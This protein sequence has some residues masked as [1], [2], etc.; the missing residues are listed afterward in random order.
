MILLKV[1]VCPGGRFMTMVSEDLAGSVFVVAPLGQG[2]A[3]AF[4]RPKRQLAA[5]CVRLGLPSQLA[6]GLADR[7]N[8]PREAAAVHAHHQVQPQT[9]AFPEA[10]WAFL[11]IGDQMARILACQHLR[12][13]PG[14]LSDPV[15]V[16]TAPEPQ[17][18]PMQHRP[19]IGRSNRQFLANIFGFFF[20]DLAQHEKMA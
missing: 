11:T 10:Q 7:G 5:F 12:L 18:S 15:P 17:S 8:L 4:T 2:L 3:D 13:P 6:Q 16:E 1:M 14:G 20:H 9:P 19:Q